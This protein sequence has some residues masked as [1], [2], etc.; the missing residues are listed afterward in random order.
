MNIIKQSGYEDS[1]LSLIEDY[2][3]ITTSDMQGII[4]AIVKS[5]YLEGFRDGK[6]QQEQDN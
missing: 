4:S 3:E 6:Q 2:Q 5:I 1:I